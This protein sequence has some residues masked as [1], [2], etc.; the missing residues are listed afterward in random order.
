MEN[1]MHEEISKVDLSAF[2]YTL[3]H[4]DLSSVAFF[5]D[6]SLSLFLT[7]FKSKQFSNYTKTRIHHACKCSAHDFSH[8]KKI[9]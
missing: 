8:D 6:V 2:I 9:S 3:F 1:F 5:I 7:N 4:K